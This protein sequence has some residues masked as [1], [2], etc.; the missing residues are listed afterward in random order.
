MKK[1]LLCFI[2][3]L[4][5]VAMTLVDGV[6][7]PGYFIKSAIKLVFFL[8]IP[9]LFSKKL[10]LS[11]SD[12]F[13][14]KKQSILTGAI[15]GVT[16]FGVILG[17]YALLHPY[18]DLSGVA[19]SLETT[20]G[21]T[22]ENFLFVGSYIALCNSLL[23]EFFFRYFAFLGLERN[24]NKLFAYIFSAA[25]FTIYHAGMLI[26]MVAPLLFALALVALFAC[27]LLLNYLNGRSQTIWVS[28]L[29]HMGAN[30]AINTVGMI[31]LGML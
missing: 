11:F 5:C 6:I 19:H 1:I 27:G 22:E 13:R 8:A 25:A 7:Q 23:E 26:T 20:A 14:P 3:V 9:L 15:L 31:L 30:L 18:L 10:K 29:L 16:S 17:A 2:V 24:G 28:W 21:V 4:G 12:A